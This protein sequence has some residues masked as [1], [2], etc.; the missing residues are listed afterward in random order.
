[1]NNQ[2][3]TKPRGPKKFV[4][5]FVAGLLIGFYMM[6][7]KTKLEIEFGQD[8]SG[9][10]AVQSDQQLKRGIMD[11]TVETFPGATFTLWRFGPEVDLID[12]LKVNRPED[13]W[14]LQDRYF[15][16]GATRKG[17]RLD[18]MIEAIVAH[19]DQDYIA[20]I[21]TDGENTGLPL[22][23]PIQLLHEDPHMRAVVVIFLNPTARLALE[24]EF[25]PL[26]ASFFPASPQSADEILRKARDYAQSKDR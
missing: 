3:L 5:V 9:S 11:A 20:V 4:P 15:T 1:M 23:Q 12:S 10:T 22:E 14:G 18:L 7:N 6:T 8:I 2:K 26:G 13:V 25:Q 16:A 21:V 17:T 19:S 24:K